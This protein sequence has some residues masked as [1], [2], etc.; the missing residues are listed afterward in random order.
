MVWM[1]FSLPLFVLVHTVVDPQCGARHLDEALGFVGSPAVLSLAIFAELRLR[2]VVG[3]V[4]GTAILKLRPYS[5]ETVGID[6]PDDLT[7]SKLGEYGETQNGWTADE[8][9]GFIKVSST[10][11]RVYYGM[12]KDEK[13]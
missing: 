2:E 3:R 1:G 13:R 4:N 12:H 8:A 10:A 11:L 5:F 6:S 7:K 9:K